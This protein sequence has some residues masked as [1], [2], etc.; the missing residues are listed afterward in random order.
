MVSYL[1]AQCCQLINPPSSR[2]FSGCRNKNQ[3]FQTQSETQGSRP[4]KSKMA[5]PLTL[6]LAVLSVV[7][8][9]ESVFYTNS[10]EN[11]FPRLGRRSYP[12]ADFS[13]EDSWA[14]MDPLQINSRDNDEGK[15]AAASDIFWQRLMYGTRSKATG[16]RNTGMKWLKHF[17][18]YFAT[19]TC[20]PHQW[21][22]VKGIHV[23]IP[24]T[25]GQ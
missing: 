2:S 21:P 8:V 23:W 1:F 3:H 25:K 4:T 14:N 20:Y 16:H 15:D 12:M 18:I 17:P 10:K 22:F 6:S 7:V 5:A 24:L 19:S 11:D 13:L 9:V